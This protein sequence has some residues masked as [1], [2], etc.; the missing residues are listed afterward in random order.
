MSDIEIQQRLMR[1]FVKRAMATANGAANG[2]TV[3]APQVPAL[4]EFGLGEAD[5]FWN[6]VEVLILTGAMKDQLRRVT[7]FVQA[8]GT[9]TVDHKF[10]HPNVSLLTVNSPAADVVIDVLDASL[11]I[12]GSLLTVDAALGDLVVNVA[13]A[14]IFNLG[15]AF[16]WD[17]V[18]PAGEVV[19]ITN[20]N[21]VLN[22]LTIAAPGIAFAG[23]Y[24]VANAASISMVDN[25]YIFDAIGT[26]ESV[27]IIGINLVANQLT[28][29]PPGIVAAGGY[30]VAVGAAISVSPSILGPI[31]GPVAVLGTQ[32]LLMTPMKT[33][34]TGVHTN[35]RRYEK[36]Y[37]FA[38]APVA[39]VGAVATALWEVAL[40]A[41]YPVAGRTAGTITTIYELH[42]ENSTGAAVTA[43]LEDDAGNTITP[44]YHIA[45]LDTIVIDWPAGFT[46]GDAEVYI[47]ASVDDVVAQI[48]GTQE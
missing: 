4:G 43:W 32:F 38:S 8:T 27:T 7:D 12:D 17:T 40:A 41:V 42:I 19:V 48:F 44:L 46:R 10:N 16:I 22:Q 3:V 14:S 18:T 34:D 6:D 24:L 5:D 39:R 25:A 11:F 2:T 26:A 23:G 45:T 37:G 29:A 21:T 9:L 33:Q 35:T 36:D 31:V 13:D 28:I 30:N 1:P 20:V 47:N 15:N